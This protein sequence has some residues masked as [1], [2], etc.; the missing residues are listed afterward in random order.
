MIILGP[1]DNDGIWFSNTIMQIFYPI[2]NLYNF[3]YLNKNIEFK[4]TNKILL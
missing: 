1:I 3:T 2:T 4:N